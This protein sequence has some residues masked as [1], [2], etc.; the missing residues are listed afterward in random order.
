MPSKSILANTPQSDGLIVAES[1]SATLGFHGVAATSQR[2]S[3]TQALVSTGALSSSATYVQA[4]ITA[5]A[6]RCSALTV[7]VNELQAALVAKGL[8]KGAA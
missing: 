1:I 8:I 5:L 3:A 7:L 2:A 4:E 6:T